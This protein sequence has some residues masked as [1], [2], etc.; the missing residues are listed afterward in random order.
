ME[1]IISRVIENPTPLEYFLG[2]E[3]EATVQIEITTISPSEYQ[4]TITIVAAGQKIDTDRLLESFASETGIDPEDLMIASTGKRE[5][6]I[7]ALT[8]IPSASSIYQ[9]DNFCV[10]TIFL[11][12]ASVI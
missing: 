2:K 10:V 4:V 12:I 5:V 11:L 6:V 8:G 9:I 7:T 1:D 3:M